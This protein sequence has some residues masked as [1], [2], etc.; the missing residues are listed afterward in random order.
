MERRVSSLSQGQRLL[1]AIMITDAVGFSTRMSIDEEQTLR[2]IDRDLTL[3]GDICHDFGGT[4]LKSTGDGLL[5]Y[6]LSA[7][8]AVSCGLEMQ[9]RLVDLA[10]GLEPE[11]YL[12]HRIGVHLG[13][14][15]VSEQ[16][17]MGNG[18]N[19]TARLQTYAK[20]RGL[21][22]SRTIYDVVKARLNLH[23]TFLGPLHLKNIDEPV[24]AYQLALQAED[25]EPGPHGSEDHTCTLPMTTEA[26]LANALRNLSTHTHSLRIKKL[27]FA[28]YQ[29]AW[30]NDPAVL[31][32]F[33]LR[34]LLLS[35]RDRYPTLPELEEQL[36]QVV[37]GLNRQDIYSEMAAVVVKQLQLWYGRSLFQNPETT[38]DESTQLTVKSIEERCQTTA[39]QLDQGSDALRI[40]KLIYC[41]CYNSWENDPGYLQELYLPGLIQQTLTVA[42]KLQD[43]RYRLGRIVKHLNRK[44]QY[45]R[46]AKLIL[47]SLHSLYQSQPEELPPDATA[48]SDATALADPSGPSGPSAESNHTTLTSLA[49]PESSV[50]LTTLHGTLSNPLSSDPE[51]GRPRHERTALF[52]LRSDILQYANPLRAKILLYSC[53]N[54]PFGYTNQ[55]WASL[56]RRTLDDL[57]QQTFDYCPT[58]ADLDSKLTIIAHC[59]GRVGDGG[60]VASTITQ[61]M[62]AY[63]PKDPNVALEPLTTAS[64]SVQP[65]PDQ[66]ITVSGSPGVTDQA[67]TVAHASAR[68]CA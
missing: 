39:E 45:A 50:D 22:V 47:E 34:S 20:P 17:V 16:D 35:L 3:I 30:E 11:Q 46:L 58:Y 67:T 42:P 5:I 23:A 44:K 59:L 40:R 26:L 7:V 61:A 9:R 32:Q 43:L 14:I 54:G 15:L 12:D 18:V 31:D 65:Q 24:P 29:K 6:F 49:Q 57:L 68:S 19:I 48:L 21:C 60:Q 27:V 52:D 13:D 66:A 36:H 41:L 2:L 56:S 55:D 28:T 51:D 53:L 37:A 62:R 25:T 38:T 4:V 1:A 63:Y 10:Q 8:E 33:D 64:S